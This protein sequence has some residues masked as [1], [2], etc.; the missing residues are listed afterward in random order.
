M[1]LSWKKT[2]AIFFG[3]Q[4]FSILTSFMVQFSIVWH[5]TV[6]TGSAAVLMIA[7]LCGFLPQA[8]L[9]PFSGVWLDRWNRKMTMIVADSTIALF[10]LILGA[11]Y[12]LGEPGLGIIYAILAIRSAASSFHA[13][14]FQA[15][16]PLIAPENQL[17][18]VAGWHQTILSFSSVI[19]PAIGIAAYSASSLGTV[20]LLDVAGALIANL[21]LVFVKIRQPKPQVVQAPSFA[22]EFRQGW[23][24]FF[25]VK[26]IVTVTIATAI[27]GIAFMPLATLFPLMTLSHFGRGGYSASLVEAAFGI[28]MILGGAMLSVLATKWK[29]TAF[30]S[31]SLTVIGMTC[32]LS[33]II[34]GSVFAGFVVLSFVMGAAAP[35]Y[36]GPFMAMIQKSFEPEKLGRVISLVT[37]FTLLSSPIGLATAGPI[38]DKYG[39]QSWFLGSGVVIVLTGMLLLLKFQRK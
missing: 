38:V 14:A 2:F 39:V 18:R 34:P 23:E 10:S 5:L 9:G 13:P 6:T 30:M 29:D 1:H 21:M 20:L 16:I 17:T 19:G 11:C 36:N 15:A 33:G 31:V 26:P 7:G 35:L 8:L 28:G 22:A 25:A 27:F 24:E 3:G 4:V 37:S 12:L 32:V